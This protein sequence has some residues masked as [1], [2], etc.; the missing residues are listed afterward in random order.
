MLNKEVNIT[1]KKKETY[2]HDSQSYWTTITIEYIQWFPVLTLMDHTAYK[3]DTRITM[4]FLL[5]KLFS[6]FKMRLYYD[7]ENLE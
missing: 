3:I 7:N 5:F 4:L 2:C 6:V 1:Y